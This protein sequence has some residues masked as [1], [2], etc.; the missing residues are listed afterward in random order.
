MP[1]AEP[2]IFALSIAPGR[3]IP[4]AAF[5]NPVALDRQFAEKFPHIGVSE[6]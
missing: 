6:T 5:A 1:R 3:A 4:A 2:D